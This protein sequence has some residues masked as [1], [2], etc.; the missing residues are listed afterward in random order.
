MMKISDFI[1]AARVW[2][3][4]CRNMDAFKSGTICDVTAQQQLPQCHDP[5]DCR[6]CHNIYCRVLWVC[7][8]HDGISVYASSGK[9]LIRAFVGR[10]KVFFVSDKVQNKH[11]YSATET[12]QRHKTLEN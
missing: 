10:K 3:T 8:R 4:D 1:S 6:R 7:W 11:A 9:R 12:I 2:S 5:D